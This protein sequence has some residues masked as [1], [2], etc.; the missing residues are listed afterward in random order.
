MELRELSAKYPEF[1]P[2]QLK[3]IINEA[4][5]RVSCG[6]ELNHGDVTKYRKI[7][8]ALRK[9]TPDN[10]VITIKSKTIRDQKITID[11]SGLVSEILELLST[12]YINH[13][14]GKLYELP[15]TKGKGK[16]K[17]INVTDY[18]TRNLALELYD[19][20]IMVVRS[21][22]RVRNFISDIFTCAN[23][24]LGKDSIKKLIS[25]RAG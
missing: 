15:D 3:V 14:T 12:S 13:A 17:G 24:P 8:N 4:T 2:I 25:K 18:W 19:I 6:K 23:Y 5:L 10:T 9:F 22:N 20:Y 7:S 21:D 1:L 16:P 11:A